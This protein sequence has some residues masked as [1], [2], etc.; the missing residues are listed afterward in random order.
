M[1]TVQE[2]LKAA[3]QKAKESISH[4]TSD[5]EQLTEEHCKTQ[6]LTFFMNGSEY[7]IDILSVQEIRGWEHTTEVPNTPSFVRGVMNLRGTIVPIIDLRERF[8][9][10]TVEYSELTVVIVVKVDCG[11]QEKVMGITVDGVS[12][13]YSI[14]ESLARLPPEVGDH[15]NR[16]FVKGLINVSDN[17]LILLNLNTVL[18]F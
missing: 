18:I 6:F 1:A 8:S 10:P 13:V 14:D 4:V 16:E 11:D 17:T 2:A 9:I 15:A 12:D 3:K 7:G 5:L